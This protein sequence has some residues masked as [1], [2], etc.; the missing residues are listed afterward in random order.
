MDSADNFGTYNDG[1]LLVTGVGIVA[2]AVIIAAVVAGQK[3]P[4]EVFCKKRC[5]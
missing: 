5:S 2:A 3:Q 4:P 1:I